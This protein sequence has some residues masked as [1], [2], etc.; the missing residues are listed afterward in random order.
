[1][2]EQCFHWSVILYCNVTITICNNIKFGLL[3]GGNRQ[4]TVDIEVLGEITQRRRL[5]RAHLF[6]LSPSESQ[7][8]SHFRLRRLTSPAILDHLLYTECELSPS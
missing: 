3:P 5:V 1:M 6:E 4:T 2:T 7:T 8:V